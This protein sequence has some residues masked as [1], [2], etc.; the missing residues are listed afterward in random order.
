MSDDKKLHN[1]PTEE[2]KVAIAAKELQKMKA[3]ESEIRKKQSAAKAKREMEAKKKELQE[4]LAGKKIAECNAKIA[5][6]EKVLEGEKAYDLIAKI[7]LVAFAFMLAISAAVFFIGLG[8]NAVLVPMI[9]A[10]VIVCISIFFQTKPDFAKKKIRDNKKRI[11]K[12]RQ[13]LYAV[14]NR[15]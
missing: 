3:K 13:E 8:A 6:A 5:K 12:I 9:I 11:T 4:A 2:Y 1:E 10:F 14:K 15:H 7:A